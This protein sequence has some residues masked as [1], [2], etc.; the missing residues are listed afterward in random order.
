MRGLEDNHLSPSVSTI[1]CQG[2]NSQSVALAIRLLL[3]FSQGF[4]QVRGRASL[5]V[6][7][8][9]SVFTHD[10]DMFGLFGR[11]NDGSVG[12]C[13]WYTSCAEPGP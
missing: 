2:S 10:N 11:V 6:E 5:G 1:H 9:E 12:G 13:G 8:E 4:G 7:L 3:D